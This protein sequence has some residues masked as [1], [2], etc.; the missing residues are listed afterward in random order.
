MKLQKW[1]ETD[2]G[3]STTKKKLIESK[4]MTA[5]WQ[6]SKGR[7]DFRFINFKDFTVMITTNGK[8]GIYYPEKSNPDVILDKL[9]AYL[10][11]AEGTQAK[12]IKTIEDKKFSEKVETYDSR[13]ATVFRYY[14]ILKKYY[15]CKVAGIIKD[16]IMDADAR[17]ARGEICNLKDY[18]NYIHYRILE[19]TCDSEAAKLAADLIVQYTAK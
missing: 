15:G 14:E 8:L 7:L 9:K 4:E 11:T 2:L 13:T 18:K 12:I 16:I 17:V 3:F 19:K 5:D 10:V 6:D 1:F